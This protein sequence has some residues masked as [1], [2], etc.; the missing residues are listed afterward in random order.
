MFV[1]A[2]VLKESVHGGRDKDQATYLLLSSAERIPP[3]LPPP[4]LHFPSSP[5]S[6]SSLGLAGLG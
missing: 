1:S 4:P 2:E 6:P 3:S 5:S